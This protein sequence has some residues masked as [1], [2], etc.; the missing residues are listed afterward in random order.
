L[1]RSIVYPE[2]GLV[3][4]TTKPDGTPRKVLDT[5]VLTELGFHPRVGLM[6]GIAETYGWF[7]EYEASRT[8]MDDVVTAG[9][10]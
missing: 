9:A 7:I 1:V 10:R 4:D 5:S 3:F 8:V 2:A 6:E